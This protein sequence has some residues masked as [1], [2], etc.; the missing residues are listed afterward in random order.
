MALEPDLDWETSSLEGFSPPTPSPI[1]VPVAAPSRKFKRPS[2]DHEYEDDEEQSELGM[3]TSSAYDPSR[4]SRRFGR[5]VTGQTHVEWFAPSWASKA[6]DIDVSPSPQDQGLLVDYIYGSSPGPNLYFLGS[7]RPGPSAYLPSSMD[8][9]DEDSLLAATSAVDHALRD[10]VEVLYPAGAC[11]IITSSGPQPRSAS[12]LEDSAYTG[13]HSDLSLASRGSWTPRQRH[14]TK[15]LDLVTAVALHPSRSLVASAERALP[16]LQPYSRSETADT[17]ERSSPASQTESS[18]PLFPPA[19]ILVWDIRT[20]DVLQE[21]YCPIASVLSLAFSPCGT[22]LATISYDTLPAQVSDQRH[23]SVVTGGDKDD[24]GPTTTETVSLTRPMYPAHLSK[25]ILKS[26]SHAGVIGDE[27][28]AHSAKEPPPGP[29]LSKHTSSSISSQSGAPVRG[30]Q[31]THTSVLSPITS[32]AH[33]SFSGPSPGHRRGHSFMG[34]D[35]NME[36]TPRSDSVSSKSSVKIMNGAKQSISSQSGA[37]ATTKLCVWKWSE[38]KLLSSVNLGAVTPYR[39]FFRSGKVG[40]SLNDDEDSVSPTTQSTSTQTRHTSSTSQKP[41]ASTVAQEI[42]VH[43]TRNGQPWPPPRLRRPETAGSSKPDGAHRMRGWRSNLTLESAKSSN[44]PRRVQRSPM[45]LDILICCDRSVIKVNLSSAVVTVSHIDG[46]LTN[47]KFV[48]QSNPPRLSRYLPSISDVYLSKPL[49]FGGNGKFQPPDGALPESSSSFSISLSGGGGGGS[50]TTHPGHRRQRSTVF[51]EPATP[52]RLSVDNSL[53]SAGSFSGGYVGGRTK[54]GA[55][56]LAFTFSDTPMSTGQALSGPITPETVLKTADAAAMTCHLVDTDDMMDNDGIHGPSK[57]IQFECLLQLFPAPVNAPNLS[58]KGSEYHEDNLSVGLG[59]APLSHASLSAQPHAPDRLHLVAGL[60]DGSLRRYID[61]ICTLSVVGHP[62]AAVTALTLCPGGF[63]SAGRDLRIVC[64]S[65][66]MVQRAAFDV[67]SSLHPVLSPSY[68][69]PTHHPSSIPSSTSQSAAPL[70]ALMKIIESEFT[71]DDALVGTG[72]YGLDYTAG[73]D[74]HSDSSP[75]HGKANLFEVNA[76]PDTSGILGGPALQGHGSRV[77]FGTDRGVIAVLYLSTAAVRTLSVAPPTPPSCLVAHPRRPGLIYI[78]HPLLPSSFAPFPSD[79]PPSLPPFQTSPPSTSPNASLPPLP[80]P[81]RTQ[82]VAWDTRLRTPVVDRIASLPSCTA[83]MVFAPLPPSL[84]PTTS[85]PTIN[86]PL[87]SASSVATTA[88]D[89]VLLWSLQ[90][91]GS[92][93]GMFPD[94]GCSIFARGDVTLM[95]TSFVT[96]LGRIAPPILATTVG[97]PS[98]SQD[99]DTSQSVSRTTACAEAAVSLALWGLQ[100]GLLSASPCGAYLALT[101][102]PLEV[103]TFFTS[104]AEWLGKTLQPP[105][106]SDRSIFSKSTNHDYNERE[107]VDV[108]ST[109]IDCLSPGHVV[110]IDAQGDLQ[111]MTGSSVIHPTIKYSLLPT[112][113]ALTSTSQIATVRSLTFSSDSRY[114]MAVDSLG[115]TG[116]VNLETGTVVS[117]PDPTFYKAVDAC[118]PGLAAPLGWH[119]EGLASIHAP[120]SYTSLPFPLRVPPVASPLASVLTSDFPS[121][122]LQFPERLHEDISQGSSQAPPS[123]SSPSPSPR[124]SLGSFPQCR[125]CFIPQTPAPLAEPSCSARGLVSLLNAPLALTRWPSLASSSTSRLPPIFLSAFPSGSVML[126]PYPLNGPQ[127]DPI[128]VT[129]SGIHADPLAT[130]LPVDTSSCPSVLSP[131]PSGALGLLV[132]SSGHTNALCGVSPL[133]T[134]RF[135]NLLASTTTEQSSNPPPSMHSVTSAQPTSFAALIRKFAAIALTR[136]G[137]KAPPPFFRFAAAA[138]AVLTLMETL[139]KSYLDNYLSVDDDNNGM[140]KAQKDAIEQLSHLITQSGLNLDLPPQ[141]L[142]H[143]LLDP[144]AQAPP[145]IVQWGIASCDTVA[146]VDRQNH[147]TIARLRR[148]RIDEQGLRVSR[149]RDQAVELRTHLGSIRIATKPDLRIPQSVSRPHF[150]TSPSLPHLHP[151]PRSLPSQH[152]LSVRPPPTPQDSTDHSLSHPLMP[153]SRQGLSSS[154]SDNNVVSSLISELRLRPDTG[155]CC[156]LPPRR[157]ERQHGF[158]PSPLHSSFS[159]ALV[160]M[161]VSKVLSSPTHSFQTD[162]TSEEK[163]ID[164]EW[165]NECVLMEQVMDAD[166]FV[167]HMAAMWSASKGDATKIGRVSLLSSESLDDLRKIRE[168]LREGHAKQSSLLQRLSVRVRKG[169]DRLSKIAH[170]HDQVLRYNSKV[171]DNM[172]SLGSLPVDYEHCS[173]NTREAHQTNRSLSP[174]TTHLHRQLRG[175]EQLRVSLE[176]AGF[177]EDQLGGERQG[178]RAMLLRQLKV[179]QGK[180]RELE[181]HVVVLKSRLYARREAALDVRQQ[182]DDVEELRRQ[183]REA[184]AEVVKIQ[185]VRASDRFAREE[186]RGHWR[187]QIRALEEDVIQHRADA[188]AATDTA[189][190]EGIQLEHL[191]KDYFDAQRQLDELAAHGW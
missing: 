76:L 22:Y 119:T 130:L 88:A 70:D 171:D 85:D 161:C 134:S 108:A 136:Y 115:R 145:L 81:V 24:G 184:S 12:S 21:I 124:D 38:G 127:R 84:V 63:I 170:L 19:R 158:P 128:P 75:S 52:S 51:I 10:T 94:E 67:G 14:F 159:R 26:L 117:P 77:V 155:V 65:D 131:T 152:A 3:T 172:N 187:A 42:S 140:I 144:F 60:S 89:G 7:Q 157:S 36:P 102:T 120:S 156:S 34:G 101:V 15:H 141:P 80:F 163:V 190:M 181:E 90:S 82:L 126:L 105:T 61:D 78:S 122:P 45:E 62:G 17:L 16:N 49:N 1:N 20:M 40:D 32:P 6:V 180:M 138:R 72:I 147:N 69:I 106:Q 91:D 111:P 185:H 132:T 186:E 162:Q 58:R 73:I 86:T 92:L 68:T 31:R 66:D 109:L 166:Q 116:Y 103:G 183:R 151:S 4:D 113:P 13:S 96:G 55:G 121:I 9:L 74:S 18:K 174:R 150:F 11:V 56:T 87:S 97:A 95:W 104:A 28:L 93:I 5:Y 142:R 139:T 83:S 8:N 98:Q 43:G 125:T 57:I 41:S 153:S 112:I 143:L 64:W 27:A 100:S 48:S 107:G 123:Q 46:I 188:K 35:F 30:H 167:S 137:I 47:T 99:H 118:Y 23:E 176:A 178:Q 53:S 191:T 148:Q 33:S 2:L 146:A 133:D 149:I 44:S 135:L 168:T 79:F 25:A 189:Q 114:L 29:S 54:G 50:A 129:F 179:A 59:S 160:P 165:T 37:I 154:N 173:D 177:A 164:T 39:V 169:A 110:I 71:K 175:H 182:I